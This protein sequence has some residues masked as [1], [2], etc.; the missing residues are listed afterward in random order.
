MSI[1]LS[2]YYLIKTCFSCDRI[3][4]IYV[5]QAWTLRENNQALGLVDPRLL[6][7]DENEA[8][9]LIGVALLCTQA[10]PMMRPPM[11]RVVA[12]LAGDIEV[13]TVT[14]KPSYITEWNYKDITS[15]FLSEEDTPLATPSGSSQPKIQDGDATS[16]RPRNDPMP[17]PN[18]V[19]E[20]MISDIIGEGR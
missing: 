10:S 4:I 11:S 18:N 12:M 8:T 3:S 2:N 6:E 14:S 15:N 7:F 9:R 19:T 5:S 17:S 1:S 16:V 13:G 20:S